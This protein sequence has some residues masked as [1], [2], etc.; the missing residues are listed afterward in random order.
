MLLTYRLRT[1]VM[2]IKLLRAAPPCCFVLPEI[3]FRDH[4][5]RLVLSEALSWCTL[6]ELDQLHAR[7]FSRL[8]IHVDVSENSRQLCCK[9]YTIPCLPVDLGVLQLQLL[10][11]IAHRKIAGR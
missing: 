6:V 5:W 11:L 8:F 9:A 2:D 1:F 7:L 4:S 10:Y 3:A